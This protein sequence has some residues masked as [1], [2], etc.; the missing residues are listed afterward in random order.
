MAHGARPLQASGMCH[1]D[2]HKVD[3]DWGVGHFPMVPG[4]EVIGVVVEV[5]R[6]V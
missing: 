1:S 4:H 2:I 5:S 3:N 6:Q